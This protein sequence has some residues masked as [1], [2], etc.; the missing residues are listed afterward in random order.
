L[1]ALWAMRLTPRGR[2]IAAPTPGTVDTVGAIHESPAN[3]P[4]SYPKQHPDK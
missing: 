1:I 3:L 2:Q 4:R